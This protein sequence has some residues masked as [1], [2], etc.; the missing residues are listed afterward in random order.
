MDVLLEE[1]FRYDSSIFPILHDR[2][3][4]P[5]Y[6]RFPWAVRARGNRALVEFPISTLR[7]GRFNLPFVGGGYLRQLPLT[8]V[9]WG[10]HRLN[11]DERRP[12]ILYVHPWE[13][14]PDQPRLPVGPVARLRHYRNLG[15]T[16]GRL[17]LLFGEF[18]F[19]TVREVLAV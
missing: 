14:D 9:R 3:G 13:V 16:E 2:Y 19:T 7:V 1:G 6:P 8:F 4:I 10:L 12:A 18:P 17:R 5:G 15:A 11:G